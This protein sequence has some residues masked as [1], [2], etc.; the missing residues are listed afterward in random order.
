MY[1]MQMYNIMNIQIDGQTKLLERR[2]QEGRNLPTFELWYIFTGS[3]NFAPLSGNDITVSNRFKWVDWKKDGF[4][5]SFQ[6]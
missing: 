2:T 6:L 1:R 4:M 3:V 5:A